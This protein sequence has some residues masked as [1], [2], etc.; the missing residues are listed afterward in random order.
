MYGP[1]ETTIWSAAWRVTESGPISIGRPIANTQTYVLDGNLHPVPVGVAGELCIAGT[2]L[3]RGYHN[4][5]EL[6]AERFVACPFTA[7]AK[8]YRT[9]DSA[10][11]L[12][13]GELEYLG[14]F[15]SQIKLRGYRIEP[16]EIEA[17]L[18]SYPGIRH[19]AV[20]L[21]ASEDRSRLIAFYVWDGARGPA[22]DASRLRDHLKR[23]LP[24]YLVPA[25]FSPLDTIPLTPNGKIDRKRLAQ[26]K[27][28][29]NRKPAS[30]RSAGGAEK[31]VAE[32]WRNVL[33]RDDVDV[34]DGF[35]ESGG[36]SILAVTLAARIRDSF[37]C[38]FDVTRL[39]E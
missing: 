17:K 21:Q 7:G 39:F 3:A 32:I 13:N 25:F 33:D 37:G 30:D 23:A 28:S 10:R 38:D 11:W 24:D 14:R 31:R 1:T 35:F 16:G 19:C 12:A 29:H 18:T 9:G 26:I 36:D 4:R 15:D 2:G 27:I 34:D 6:T 22:P 20:V 8:L 5:P